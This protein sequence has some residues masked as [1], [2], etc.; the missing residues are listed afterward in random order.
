MCNFKDQTNFLSSEQLSRMKNKRFSKF[1]LFLYISL[2][3]LAVS[4]STS[5]FIVSDFI[6][7]FPVRVIKS[8]S[9]WEWMSLSMPLKDCTQHQKFTIV[10]I[11]IWYPTEKNHFETL[12]CN[13]D[14]SD[15]NVVSQI[16]KNI[17]FIEV[18]KSM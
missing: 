3:I 17:N 7:Q 15:V 1:D 5:L 6:S 9:I 12:K 10:S 8:I 18:I 13:W 16:V 11:E 4:K 14:I 2:N